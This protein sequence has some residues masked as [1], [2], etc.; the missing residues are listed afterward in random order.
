VACAIYARV[1]W[2]C[3]L[4]SGERAREGLCLCLCSLLGGLYRVKIL[5]WARSA[6]ILVM[7]IRVFSEHTNKRFIVG[8]LFQSLAGFTK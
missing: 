1:F 2:L 5:V 6:K 7:Y 8:I 4:T 3:V